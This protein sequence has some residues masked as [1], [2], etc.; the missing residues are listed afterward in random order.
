MALMEDAK[1]YW[2]DF[3][4]LML[5][6]TKFGS[7]EQTRKTGNLINKKQ[8][9]ESLITIL[10][11][12]A[13]E[14]YGRTSF[15]TEYLKDN[16]REEILI[17]EKTNIQLSFLLVKIEYENDVEIKSYID[18]TDNYIK[19]FIGYLINLYLD[20]ETVNLYEIII[21]ALQ[22]LFPSRIY[23][24]ELIDDTNFKNMYQKNTILFIQ[25]KISEKEEEPYYDF[26]KRKAVYNLMLNMID[27]IELQIEQ[28]DSI[29]LAISNDFTELDTDHIKYSINNYKEVENKLSNNNKKSFIDLL[30]KKNKE[31][32]P[33]E[34]N[35]NNNN[36]KTKLQTK[37]RLSLQPILSKVV[38]K[39]RK[40]INNNFTKKLSLLSKYNTSN[41]KKVISNMA[42]L[43]A[44]Y[45]N[46]P[47]T[48]KKEAI[49][50]LNTFFNSNPKSIESKQQEILEKMK[51]LLSK[52]PNETNKAKIKQNISIKKTQLKS[53]ETKSQSESMNALIK[54]LDEY[55]YLEKSSE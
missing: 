50:K 53:N 11:N 27:M 52:Y 14:Y 22:K 41:K 7:K 6:P 44:E 33:L 8:F 16:I 51:K 39:G 54:Y 31:Y 43:K 36:T 40:K 35:N 30:K 34:I 2:S 13:I 20:N 3:K 37:K 15:I 46:K 25:D 49:K 38:Q 18:I 19:V 21:T 10:I 12:S 28:L 23:S 9:N 1:K 17:N 26:E 4:N 32:E 24:I 5:L 29:Y 45:S 55:V 47:Y 48:G 42:G